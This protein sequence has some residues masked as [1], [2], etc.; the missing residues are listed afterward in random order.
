MVYLT[1]VLTN[2]IQSYFH[3]YYYYVAV[4]SYYYIDIDITII[5]CSLVISRINECL[6]IYS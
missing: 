2:F 4:A 3:F 5:K 6:L 1:L